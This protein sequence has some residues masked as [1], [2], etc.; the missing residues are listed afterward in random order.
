M[1]HLKISDQK[2]NIQINSTKFII[3]LGP[4]TLWGII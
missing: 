4:K 1:I 2:E 3:R